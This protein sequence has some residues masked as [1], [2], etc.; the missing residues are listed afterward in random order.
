MKLTHALLGE[1]AIFYALFDHVERQL[2][3]SAELAA[4]QASGTA[5]AEA[6]ISHA[7]LEDELLFPALDGSPA[8]DG[9]VPVM[10]AE[11]AEIDSLCADL[12]RA[13]DAEDAAALLGEVIGLAREHFAKEEQVLFPMVER[14]VADDELERLTNSWARLRG[15]T[16][17]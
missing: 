17:G 5:L 12:P 14:F 7:K 15:V 11:H 1:H 10:R 13:T 9:P 6:L 3:G 2:D 8:G 4:L 16:L